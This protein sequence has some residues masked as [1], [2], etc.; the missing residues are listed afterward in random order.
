MSS[1]KGCRSVS[2]SGIALSPAMTFLLHE[3]YHPGSRPEKDSLHLH[4]SP[5]PHVHQPLPAVAGAGLGEEHVDDLRGV[6]LA[7]ED[8][9]DEAAGLAGHGGLAELE[10]VHLAQALEELD[11]GLALLSLGFDAVEDPLLLPF[12]ERVVDLLAQVDAV[13]RGHGDVDVTL[14]HERPE[15][16]QEE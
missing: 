16:A 2:G 9:L 13:E 15:V 7:V 4:L 14:F 3:V 10:G 5:V 6:L 11:I 12:V 1:S 8:E